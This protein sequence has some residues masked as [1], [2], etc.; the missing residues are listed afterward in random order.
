VD[1][2]I[3]ASQSSLC[4]EA[5]G[6]YPFQIGAMTPTSYFFNGDIA[7]IQLYNRALTPAEIIR[8]DENLA[9]TYGVA[10]AA[11]TVVVWG[12]NA[13][14][15]ANVPTG[16]T[17]V[18][19]VASG[20]QSSFNLALAANGTVQAWGSNSQGQTNVPAGLTNVA[21][22]AAGA[23]FGMAIGNEPPFA[24]NTTVSG[25]VNHDLIIP[26]PGTSPDGNAL[27]FQV[28][29][30]PA[31]GALYQYAAGSRGLL[32]NTNNTPVSDPGG[33]VIFA[34]ASGQTGSPYAAFNFICNDGFYIS[35]AA[36]VTIN[37]GL[38]VA[39]QYTGAVWNPASLGNASFTLNFSG[40]SNATY[41]VWAATN[42]FDWVNIGTATEAPPGEYEYTDVSVTNWP[43]RFYRLA[44]P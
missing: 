14:G 37:I 1:G 4:P 10:G 26:L 2:A 12:N 41:S 5:R 18:W 6:N 35:S 13:S 24:T 25:Y 11:G 42:L 27:N 19:A 39:P 28:Q 32:I 43:Q 40:P 44:A 8:T 33:R 23:V 16:L 17:N 3:V 7:E 36:T 38:P 29:T 34:P 22:V 9:A 15:Q 30:L 20:V 31:V 21:A